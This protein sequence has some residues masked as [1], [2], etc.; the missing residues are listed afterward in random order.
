MTHKYIVSVP[1]RAVP[2]CI[3][4]DAFEAFVGGKRFFLAGNV[5]AEVPAFDLLAVSTALPDF[6]DL[7]QFR[8][9]VREIRRAGAARYIEPLPAQTC[10]VFK[11]SASHFWPYVS[12]VVLSMA[13]GFGVGLSYAGVW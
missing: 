9:A 1:G 13:V 11:T 4:A 5:V 12:A 3:E 6:P 10:A 2:F 7:S 8:P